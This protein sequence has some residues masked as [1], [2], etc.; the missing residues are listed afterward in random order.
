MIGESALD[1]LF[2]ALRSVRA[3]LIVLVNLPRSLVGGVPAVGLMGGALSVSS[4]VGFITLLGIAARNGTMTVSHCQHLTPY[5]GE[6]FTES[7]VLRGTR[8]RPRPVLMAATVAAL[9]MVP[10]APQQGC[11]MRGRR[12]G[13]N[14]PRT[15]TQLPASAPPVCSLMNWAF[16]ASLQKA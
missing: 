1:E 15:L 2:V 13:P 8:E 4:L 11:A 3:T 16:S 6:S 10:P 12:S 7:M 5:E 9:A 14:R